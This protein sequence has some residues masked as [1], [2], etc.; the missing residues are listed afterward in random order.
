MEESFLSHLSKWALSTPTK[1]AATFLDSGPNGGTI[2]REITYQNL[3]ILS[4]RLAV[5]LLDGALR[6]G[7]RY[8]IQRDFCTD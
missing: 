6:T 3:Q 1:I 2:V 8:V 4:D 5:Q 7:D